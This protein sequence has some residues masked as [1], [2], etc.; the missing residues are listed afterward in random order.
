MTTF[1]TILLAGIGDVIGILVPI[2]FFVIYALNQLLTAKS[3]QQPQ[4]GGQRRPPERGERPLR[5]AQPQQPPQ[6]RPQGN[7]A[8]QLNSEIEQ[9]LK[10][11]SQRRGERPASERASRAAAA[12]PKAPPKP[13]QEEPADVQPIEHRDFDSVTASVEKHLSRRGFSERA[14][15]LADDIVRADE[16]MEQHLQKAFG[17]RV[18]TLSSDAASGAPVT[19]V[20]TAV[21]TDAPSAAASLAAALASPQGA[22]Q[23]L[24]LGEILAR[25]EH[26]W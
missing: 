1:T 26:R 6:Q 20:E 5:P 11:A 4:R 21:K 24:V 14:E 17:H 25:P 15:H 8:S 9:F 19:D 7:H 3:A 22:R 18:G 12:P 2:V 16:Q 13:P 23:A 10:R